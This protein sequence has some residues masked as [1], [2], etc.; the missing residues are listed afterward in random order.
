M[1]RKLQW[2]VVAVIMTIVTLIL[3]VLF[4]F[5]YFS[6]WNDLQETATETLLRAA[7]EPD[8][9]FPLGDAGD[10]TRLPTF[11]LET[12][13]QG[14][15]RRVAGSAAA[16]TLADWQAV[17]DA[18]RAQGTEIGTLKEFSLRF[19]C[20]RMPDGAWRVTCADWSFAAGVLRSLLRNMAV[21]GAAAL[22]AFFLLSVGLARWMT[23]PVERAWD[24]QRQFAADASH[25]LKTPLTVI[26]ANADM[27]A[28]HKEGADPA[29]QRWTDNIRVEAAQM[30]CLVEELLSLARADVTEQ[31]TERVP[32]DLSDVVE[33]GVLT[34][35]PIVYERGLRMDS[36]IELGCRTMGN[37]AQW[38]QVVDILLDNG[39][40]Y[41]LPG[42]E[43]KVE[44]RTE[45]SRSILLRVSN[46]S[47]P[48]SEE[49]LERLFD[50]FYRRD[51]ARSGY[52]GYGLGLSI[53]QKLVTSFRGRIWA[54]H[55]NG[56]TTLQIRLPQAAPKGGRSASFQ[57]GEVN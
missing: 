47:E 12:D 1:I 26:L 21:I 13:R 40:K 44:L 10:R 39:V 31:K 56:V 22:A 15:V 46:P 14:T 54:E 37:E 43:I 5:F 16:D 36:R 23:R 24:R 55:R 28:A 20:Q 6:T 52:T 11:T 25:E 2:K 7:H 57:E 19:Y 17:A 49:E 53:A 50:R 3:A 42:G 34:F 9:L 51:Q 38:R 4:A 32:V 41:A 18:A 29:A 27:L 35:E 33:S 48:I 30:R 45:G 8:R